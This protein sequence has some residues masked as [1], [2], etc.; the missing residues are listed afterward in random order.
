[1]TSIL[2]THCYVHLKENNKGEVFAS[3]GRKHE[4]G[5]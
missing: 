2:F 1:M 3:G 4:D 5:S